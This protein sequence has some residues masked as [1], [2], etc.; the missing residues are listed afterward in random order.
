MQQSQ[1]QI[2]QRPAMPSS[3]PQRL[4]KVSPWPF[5]A[6]IQGHAEIDV[7]V[8]AQ[9]VVATTARLWLAQTDGN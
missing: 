3:P 2:S 6:A 9:R 7:M 1:P 4:R 8:N 5:R